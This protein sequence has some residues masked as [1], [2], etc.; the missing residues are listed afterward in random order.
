MQP[1]RG[2]SPHTLGCSQFCKSFPTFR[3]SV[4]F[5]AAEYSTKAFSCHWIRVA[6][7]FGLKSAHNFFFTL[8]TIFYCIFMHQF[9]GEKRTQL[10]TLRDWMWIW[11]S[12]FLVIFVYFMRSAAPTARNE[13]IVFRQF[14]S[15][16]IYRFLPKI[17]C[18]SC[19]YCVCCTCGN[20]LNFIN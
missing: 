13:L 12:T 4:S 7:C 16:K 3:F 10:A 1:R 5:F 17:V 15:G 2:T 6:N 14:L 18:L 8:K 19:N 20:K 9:F 11:I